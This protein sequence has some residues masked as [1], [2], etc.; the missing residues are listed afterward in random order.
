MDSPQA[1]RWIE[2]VEYV[3]VNRGGVAE[4][5]QLPGSN[6]IPTPT[7]EQIVSRSY[8]RRQEPSVT[9]IGDDSDDEDDF[10]TTAT[11]ATPSSGG[12]PPVRTRRERWQCEI[13]Y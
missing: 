10:S 7:V 13:K 11:T 2:K 6:T 12:P 1:R 3:V 4:E 9:G 5:V 8:A